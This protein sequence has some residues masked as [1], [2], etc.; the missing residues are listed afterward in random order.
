MEHRW[1]LFSFLERGWHKGEAH[2]LMCDGQ[3]VEAAG[4]EAVYV[5]QH[6][7]IE[8]VAGISWHENRWRLSLVKLNGFGKD[9][10]L[11]ARVVFV[12]DGARES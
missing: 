11:C 9:D 8:L 4:H 12:G 7:L 1:R 5:L 2:D 6:A 3:L 10:G